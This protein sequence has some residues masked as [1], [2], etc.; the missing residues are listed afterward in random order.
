MSKRAIIISGGSMYDNLAKTV[1][2]EHYMRVDRS[3]QRT[4][5]AIRKWHRANADCWRF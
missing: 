1:L 5:L 3:R 4:L 2:G